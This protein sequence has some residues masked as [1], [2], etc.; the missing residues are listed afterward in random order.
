MESLP[1]CIGLANIGF[2]ESSNGH[3]RLGCSCWL[4]KLQPSEYTVP[5]KHHRSQQELHH[6]RRISSAQPN[7]NGGR[8]C[9]SSNHSLGSSPKSSSV[10][11][12]RS[13]CQVPLLAQEA[14][15]EIHQTRD[16]EVPGVRSAS[17]EV[18]SGCPRKVQVHRPVAN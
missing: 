16:R 14:C 3:P 2:R 7:W 4:R 9:W 13:Y 12:L 1:I 5:S 10:P 18:Q 15:L 17:Q 11:A 8:Q 6:C